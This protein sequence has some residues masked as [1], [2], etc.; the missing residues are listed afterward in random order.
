MSKKRM[1]VDSDGHE[2][3]FQRRNHKKIL[4]PLAI[5]AGGLASCEAS[6]CQVRHIVWCYFIKE[7]GGLALTDTNLTVA[8]KQQ[9]HISC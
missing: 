9:F 2:S 8:P 7:G 3:A 6:P 1:H 4:R 5:E